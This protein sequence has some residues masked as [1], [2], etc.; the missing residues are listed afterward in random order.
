MAMDC[1]RGNDAQRAR[2]NGLT[3]LEPLQ[4][5]EPAAQ[6]FHKEMLLLQDFYNEFLKGASA[7][8]RGTLCQLKNLFNFRQ[9]KADISDKFSH[10]WELMCLDVEGF[11]C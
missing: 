9:V 3:E 8:D 10:A 5:L 2:A 4:G 7:S 11:T 6:E 1:E